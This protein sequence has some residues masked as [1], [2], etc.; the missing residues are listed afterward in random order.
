MNSQ[1]EYIQWQKKKEADWE[2]LCR[3]CGACCGVAEGNPCEHVMLMED[4]RY[5]CQIYENRFGEHKTTSG[6]ICKC[7]PIREILHQ[8]W[9]GDRCCGYKI[10]SSTCGDKNHEKRNG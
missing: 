2:D 5:G 1:E 3:R 10:K 7:V 9:I 8:S 4:G 6:K